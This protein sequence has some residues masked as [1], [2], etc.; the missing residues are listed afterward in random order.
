MSIGEICNRNVVVIERGAAVQEAA[1]LMRQFHVGALVV[2]NEREGLRV[3]VGLV[4]DRDLVIE[5]LGQEV[6]VASIL[7]GDIMSV[8]LL[9]AH[10]SD[11]LWDTLQRMR[12]AGVRRMPVVDAQG[13]LQGIVTMDD[14]IELL[15]DELAQLAKLVAQEQRVEQAGR[16]HL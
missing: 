11:E 5:V 14:V 10:E 15:A 4:T 16:S 2:C 6:D 12:A 7:V 8:K 9:I 13:S 3:P 1:R